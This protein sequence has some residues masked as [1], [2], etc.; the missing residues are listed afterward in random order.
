VVAKKSA[1]LGHR[2]LFRAR[3]WVRDYVPAVFRT[4]WL[5]FCGARIGAHTLIPEVLISWPH[6]LDIGDWCVLESGIT[7][8]FD[9]AW[10]P[11]PSI[12]IRDRVFMGQGCELNLK[13]GLTIGQGSAIASGCKFIDHDHGITG[14]RID[15]TPGAESQIT[16]GS[17]VWLGCNVVVLKGVTIGSG[18]VVGAGAVVTRSIPAN[19]I[20]GG[21]P[22]RRLSSREERAQR[23]SAGLKREAKVQPQPALP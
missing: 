16:I 19:E 6:Q 18:A 13:K 21:V 8:K 3:H 17:Y 7:F 23:V 15:E 14:D 9:G 4:A 10:K 22:A 11:G 20:W 2:L 5:R 12:L 1:P